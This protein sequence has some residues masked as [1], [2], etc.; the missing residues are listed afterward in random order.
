MRLSYSDSSG[1]IVPPTPRHAR[2]NNP[3]KIFQVLSRT[4]GMVTYV[5]VWI[6]KCC[7]NDRDGHVSVQSKTGT[8]NVPE[9]QNCIP[10]NV[11]VL[12]LRKTKADIFYPLTLAICGVHA[13]D[14]GYVQ[15]LIGIGALKH[16]LNVFLGPTVCKW[17]HKG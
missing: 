5:L 10:P 14:Y 8:S 17:S 16:G 6:V 4:L 2:N 7:R 13:N 12:M 15:Q 11:K 1:V 3:E 9:T